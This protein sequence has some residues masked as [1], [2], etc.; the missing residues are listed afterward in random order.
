M[1]ILSGKTII[2]LGSSVT[3]G[4]AAEGESF[5]DLLEKYDGIKAVKEAVS[6][7][8]LADGEES[9][10]T[11]MKRIGTAVRADCFVCQ[12]S[13]NDA[14]QK[15]PVG[16]ISESHRMEDFDTATVIGAIEYI[17]AYARK[18][19]KCPVA[20]YTGTYYESSI[21]EELVI[22]LAKLRQK[23][24]IGVLDLWNDPEMNRVTAEDYKRY[25]ED[26]IHPTAAGYREWWLPRFEQYLEQFLK[27]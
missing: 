15:K 27:K 18:V 26:P 21:Y 3:Y 13:T 5:V 22:Q 11:R 14:S 6:G 1:G 2:F 23:W 25:M 20:F 16:R 17:I 4:A 8:T 10:I 19:W 24:G 9:Y 7:T 12:L